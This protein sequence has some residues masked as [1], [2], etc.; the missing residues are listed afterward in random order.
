MMPEAVAH[1]VIHRSSFRP[2]APSMPNASLHPAR[3]RRPAQRTGSETPSPYWARRHPAPTGFDQ[4]FGSGTTI[5]SWDSE[6]KTTHTSF[7]S[8]NLQQRSPAPVVLESPD[9]GDG[10]GAGNRVPKKV[11][12]TEPQE[13]PPGCESRDEGIARRRPRVNE[14]G[15]D[16]DVDVK[17]KPNLLYPRSLRVLSRTISKYRSISLSDRRA[18]VFQAP[19]CVLCTIDFARP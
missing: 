3:I 16:V 13:R 18:T 4:R 6:K 17:Q 19:T 10:G 7:A 1:R 11:V 8:N 5:P 14:I 12:A 2:P 9:D 15:A